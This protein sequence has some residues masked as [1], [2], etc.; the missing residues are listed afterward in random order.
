MY[1]L[2]CNNNNSNN[3]NNKNNDNDNDYDNNN[4]KMLATLNFHLTDQAGFCRL[5]IKPSSRAFK[6]KQGLVSDSDHNSEEDSDE[7]DDDDDDDDYSKIDNWLI[8]I[9]RKYLPLSSDGSWL[10]LENMSTRFSAKHL[11]SADY[12]WKQGVR[13]L[14]FT[15]LPK[16]WV[17]RGMSKFLNEE[18]RDAC[19]FITD[20]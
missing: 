13:D 20:L 18:G 14:Q 1:W 7:Y 15:F 9:Y 16:S 17:T 3:N 6:R 8:L 10:V 2:A 4:N 19:Q 12:F 11:H 5:K